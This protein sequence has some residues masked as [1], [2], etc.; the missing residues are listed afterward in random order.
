MALRCTSAWVTL[1]TP[2]FEP[3]VQFYSQLLNASPHPYLPNAYAEFQI[4]G[5]R[6]GIFNPKSEHR[7]EFGDP[8]G[9]AMSLCFEVDNLEEAIARVTALG[10]SLPYDISTASH[11]RE[12]YAYDPAGNRLILHQSF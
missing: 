8:A 7:A 2:S 9:A 5:L 3:L 1:A 11:G 4:A 6:I 12:V 10:C